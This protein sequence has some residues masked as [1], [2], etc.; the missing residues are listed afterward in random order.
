M[1]YARVGGA[2]RTRAWRVRGR[3]ARG[4][5][6]WEWAAGEGEREGLPVGQGPGAGR[7][8][9]RDVMAVPQASAAAVLA[10]ERVGA[11]T[12]DGRREGLAAAPSA[13]PR[14]VPAAP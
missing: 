14:R 7:A 2:S 4:E 12:G 1:P 8:A 13:A 11:A 9:G 6:R 3:G 10:T 5:R